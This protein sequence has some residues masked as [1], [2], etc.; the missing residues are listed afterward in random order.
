MPSPFKA[1]KPN[2][3]KPGSLDHDLLETKRD[4]KRAKKGE[5]GEVSL[6]DMRQTK[7]RIKREIKDVEREEAEAYFRERQKDTEPR[8]LSPIYTKPPHRFL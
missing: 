8:Q 4:I 7:K 1:M 2:P 5:P 6:D 3:H